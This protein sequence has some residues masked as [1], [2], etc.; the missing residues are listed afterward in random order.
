MNI[1]YGT[2]ALLL[3]GALAS[4]AHTAS[5][6]AVAR[7]RGEAFGEAMKAGDAALL[8]FAREHAAL[9][10][11]G[12]ARA[13]AFVA[14]MKETLAEL[15]PVERHQV[16]VVA[17][18]RA[19][20][21]YCKHGKGG[22]WQ[23]YQFQVAA[24]DANRLQLVFRAVAVEPLERPETA[25]DHP[26]S[27]KWMTK[28]L[29]AL[30]AQQ[31]FSGVAVVRQKG[32]EIFSLAKGIAD[33]GPRIP[34]VRSTR[35]GMASGSKMFTAVAILQLAQAGK[36]ALSDPLIKHLPAFPNAEFAKRATLHQLLTHTAGAGDYWDDAYEKN[37]DSI[38][39]TKQ[40]LPFVL[41]HLG[42]SAPGEFSYSNSGYILLGLVIE[43]VSG[44]SYY[45]Y[46]QKNILA[47]AGMGSTGYPIRGEAAD[48]ALPYN[49]EM[50]AGLVQPG[51]FVPVKLG[52]RGTS[53]GGASTT[54]DDMLRFSDALQKGMLIDN[55]HL[56]LMRRGHVAYGGQWYGYAL[57]IEQKDG[58]PSWGHGGTARGTHFEFRVFPNSDTTLVVMSNYN[59]I[60]GNEIASALDDLIRRTPI[61]VK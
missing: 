29:S 27:E 55:T 21:V 11:G 37:W 3:S 5:V 57:I 14:R 17:G 13:A 4:S 59:T 20:F 1:R 49:P 24:G 12:E 46:V 39:E 31:P 38:V 16:Q 10:G 23:N 33:N 60:A 58:V 48:L 47:P 2:L 7:Q 18:G 25:L 61:P 42:G 51:V 19:V 32:K 30:E 26:E 53:A 6:E 43:A 54:V 8:A 40:M 41:T 28:F 56:D 22:A 45:E 35:F 50:D 36:L 9:S 44:R 34:V 15:G 52:A